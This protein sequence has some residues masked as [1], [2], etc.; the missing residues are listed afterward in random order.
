M[1]GTDVWIDK[2][3]QWVMKEKPVSER[4]IGLVEAYFAGEIQEKPK[5]GLI[6]SGVRWEI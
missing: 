1:A 4:R 5:K 2:I 3:K 6:K